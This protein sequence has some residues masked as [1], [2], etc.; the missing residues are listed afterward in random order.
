MHLADW[1]W[2]HDPVTLVVLGMHAGFAVGL[3]HDRQ[4]RKDA[5]H[6]GGVFGVGP[7][8]NLGATRQPA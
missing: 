1:A 7:L 3:R 5:G 8:P 4:V 2:P 6:V